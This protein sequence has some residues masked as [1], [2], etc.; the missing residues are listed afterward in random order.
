MG[1][2]TKGVKLWDSLTNGL[3][4]IGWSYYAVLLM[5]VKS[6]QKLHGNFRE[7]KSQSQSRMYH[8]WKKFL[9]LNWAQLWMIPN[10][11]Q[12][13]FDTTRAPLSLVLPF[14]SVGGWEDLFIKSLD[15][16]SNP[17]K[18]LGHDLQ[19]RARHSVHH[20]FVTT[21]FAWSDAAATIYFVMQ[22]CAASIREQLL[23]E[24]GVY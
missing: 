15:T 2:A 6:S 13:N 9:L 22:F 18:F 10:Q 8:E 20:A 23:I 11:V 5:F 24:S 7:T 1:V 21:V 16:S 3:T 19:Q 17:H 4:R 14:H 12:Q